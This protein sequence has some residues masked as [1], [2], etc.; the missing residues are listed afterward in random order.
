MK[1]SLIVS[2]TLFSILLLL[3]GAYMLAMGNVPQ[4]PD[5]IVAP[6]TVLLITMAVAAVCLFGVYKNEVWALYAFLL[7]PTFMTTLFLIERYRAE[8]TLRAADGLVLSGFVL[9]L[10]LVV[11]VL[12]ISKSK[13]LY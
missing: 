1:L 4:R 7:L 5:L 11:R 6:R 2:V 13:K 12:L 10:V 3:G 9:V 8:Q